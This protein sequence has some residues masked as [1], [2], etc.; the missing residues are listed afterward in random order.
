ML[1]IYEMGEDLFSWNV[2]EHVKAHYEARHHVHKSVPTLS[3]DARIGAH[4]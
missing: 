1:E 2:R 4:A 3:T